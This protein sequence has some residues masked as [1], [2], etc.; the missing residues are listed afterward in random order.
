MIFFG[1]I[2]QKKLLS[3]K[4]LAIA[5]FVLMLISIMTDAF[6]AMRIAANSMPITSS[7]NTIVELIPKTID[8]YLD[9]DRLG[10][11]E[12]IHANLSSRTFV[13]GYLALLVKASSK[14]EPLYGEDFL[15]A[16]IISMPGIL[17]PSK[18]NRPHYDEEKLFNVNFRTENIVDAAGS[19]STAGVG[20]FGIY[21]LF[22]YPLIL[23]FA[24]SVFLRFINRLISPVKYFFI[25]MIVCYSF[26]SLE[27]D[28][29]VFILNL[30]NI[31]FILFILWLFFNFN[32]KKTFSNTSK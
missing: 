6:S 21:G 14:F 30:R 27:Q 31:L 10:V 7:K 5:V 16:V 9:S 8:V 26:I 3:L 24:Y 18:Y 11:D 32:S 12:K 15:R 23:C 17:Y 4:S 20:D 22:G 1:S 29:A 13:L 19:I 28:I 25:S 2:D